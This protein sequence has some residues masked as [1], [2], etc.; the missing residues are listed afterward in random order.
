RLARGLGDGAE[1]RGECGGIGLVGEPAKEDRQL[2]E[3]VVLTEGPEGWFRGLGDR[4]GGRAHDQ[5]LPRGMPSAVSIARVRYS[6]L[7]LPSV[8]AT[9]A[10]TTTCA[11]RRATR[12]AIAAPAW[13][14]VMLMMSLLSGWDAASAAPDH[15]QRPGAKTWVTTT[16]RLRPGLASGP[17]PR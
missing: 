16:H 15:A 1:L 10:K 2:L 5:S 11:A 3:C 13:N 7:I 12:W 14:V 17:A 9:A 6:P 8:R 4:C